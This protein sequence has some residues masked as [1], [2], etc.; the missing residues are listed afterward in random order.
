MTATCTSM[1]QYS[2]CCSSSAAGTSSVR[3]CV[4]MDTAVIAVSIFI[5]ILIDLLAKQS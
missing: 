1:Y 3:L 5:S 4:I 2:N